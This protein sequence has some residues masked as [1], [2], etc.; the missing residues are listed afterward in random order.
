MSATPGHTE[1]HP[2]WYRKRVSTY[3]WMARGAYLLFILRELSSVFVAWSVVLLLWLARALS[4]GPEAYASLLAACR[5][6]LLMGLNVISLGFVV[7]H[8]VTWFQ[9]APRAMVVHFRGKRVPGSWVLAANFAA[10]AGV[11]AVVAWLVLRGT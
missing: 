1:F 5:H 7:L 4:Q 3:W 2:R 8:A 9:L 11:S 10:W 6:P